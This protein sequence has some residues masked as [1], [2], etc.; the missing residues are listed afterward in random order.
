MFLLEKHLRDG[1]FLTVVVFDIFC[2]IPV[3]E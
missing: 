2:S 1:N 3:E